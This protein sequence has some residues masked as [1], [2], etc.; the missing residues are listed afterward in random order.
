MRDHGRQKG[1]GEIYHSHVYT[2][3][4]TTEDQSGNR[5][6]R[7]RFVEKA[8]DAI[9]KAAAKTEINDGKIFIY[10]VDQV[11]RIRKPGARGDS[12]YQSAQST[13]SPIAH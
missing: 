13:V 9:V 4:L 8:V 3:N 11:V 2:M 7:S 10:K 5:A 12:T 1:H 6:G